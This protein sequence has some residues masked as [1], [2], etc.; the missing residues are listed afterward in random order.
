MC[1]RKLGFCFHS[2]GFCFSLGFPD[3][4][5]GKNKIKPPVSPLELLGKSLCWGALNLRKVR[6][7]AG[8]HFSTTLSFLRCVWAPTGSSGCRGWAGGQ[9]AKSA[10]PDCVCLGRR[11]EETLLM[12]WKDSCIIMG[13]KISSSPPVTKKKKITNFFFF[14][15]HGA[16][17]VALVVKNLLPKQETQETQVQ[18]LGWED[19]LEEGMTTHSSILAWRISMDRGG[20]QL[21]VHG[22]VKS[23]TR[24]S[25]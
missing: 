21:T 18:S 7:R 5:D 24:P 2:N 9:S 22:V 20:W 13:V 23:R 14:L 16:S 1:V 25:D 17:Q 3:G 12:A 10:K 8:N 15:A 19:P 6:S 11:H 4:S